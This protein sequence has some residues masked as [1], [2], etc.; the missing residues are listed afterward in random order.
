MDIRPIR[1]GEDHRRALRDVERLWAA[2]EGTPEGDE[3][4]VLANLIEAYENR[5]YPMLN[6]P[7]RSHPH[8]PLRNRGYG[9][10]ASRTAAL[11]GSRARASEVLNRR[12]RLTIEMVA[13][14]SEAWR[15]PVEA[16]GMP[17]K[18]DPS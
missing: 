1:K 18:V 14:A 4:D 5:Y 17:C 13:T 7:C 9:P 11:L 10:F 16:L 12:R 15:I 2:Q 3:L 8:P 6:A